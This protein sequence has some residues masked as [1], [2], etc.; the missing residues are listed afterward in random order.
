M[1]DQEVVVLLQ[2]ILDKLGTTGGSQAIATDHEFI[3]EVDVSDTS[4]TEISLKEN[5]F[6]VKLTA[7][8]SDIKVNLDRPITLDEYIIIPMDTSKVIRRR[9]SKIYAQSLN[10]GGKLLVEALVL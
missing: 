5:T 6:V 3:P 10:P 8:Y 4:Q 1:T 2:K 9:V 7:K